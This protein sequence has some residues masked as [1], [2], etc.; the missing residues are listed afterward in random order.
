M[1]VRVR[2]QELVEHVTIRGTQVSTSM[3]APSLM[4]VSVV[5]TFGMPGRHGHVICDN[6]TVYVRYDHKNTD[7]VHI[8]AYMNDPTSEEDEWQCALL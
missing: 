3:V 1:S 4:H 7:H 2:V 6:Y 5:Q 8:W